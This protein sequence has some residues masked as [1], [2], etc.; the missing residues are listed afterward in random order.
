MMIAMSL[1]CVVVVAVPTAKR[2]IYAVA[3]VSLKPTTYG[4]H[5]PASR[6]ATLAVELWRKLGD[7]EVRKAA[8]RGG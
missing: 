3:G 2:L 7:D 6:L 8:Y 5:L 4:L 1:F